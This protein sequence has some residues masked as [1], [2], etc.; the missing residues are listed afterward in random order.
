M[1]L[2]LFLPSSLLFCF[3]LLVGFQ[4]CFF[5]LIEKKV[6]IFRKS[7]SLP[8]LA[9][10]SLSLAVFVCVFPVIAARHEKMFTK[11]EVGSLFSN[12]CV[13]FSVLGFLNKLKKRL[14]PIQRGFC[15]VNV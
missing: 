14:K 2:L 9:P 8:C 3:V 5:F 15:L 4:F 12:L 6:K 13:W 10:L 11:N 1:V 7:L